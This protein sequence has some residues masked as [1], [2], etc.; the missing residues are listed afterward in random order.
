MNFSMQRKGYYPPQK[1][2]DRVTTYIGKN[3]S[4]NLNTVYTVDF[5]YKYVKIV[6]PAQYLIGP[7]NIIKTNNIAA[8]YHRQC[9]ARFQTS[10]ILPYAVVAL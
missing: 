6:R 8:L 3:Y 10:V 4:I 5:Q 1:C 9:Q 2:A 7:N